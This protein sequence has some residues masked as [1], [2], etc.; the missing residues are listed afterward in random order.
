MFSSM[1]KGSGE[2]QECSQ[3]APP[4]LCRPLKHYYPKNLLR[5]FVCLN[6]FSEVIFKDSP[7]LPFKTSIKNNLA[8]LFLFVEVIFAS[9]GYF[10]KIASKDS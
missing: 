6:V 3:I 7:K 10:L 2:P 4:P 5:L 8:R 9:R 1:K